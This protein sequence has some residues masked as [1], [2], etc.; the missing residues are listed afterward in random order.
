MTLKHIITWT[1]F[2]SLSLS[3]CSQ[4]RESNWIPDR[5]IGLTRGGLSL[6]VIASHTLNVP[7]DTLRVSLRDAVAPQETNLDIIDMAAS[8]KHILIMD[9]INDSGETIAWIKKNW[10]QHAGI[11][12]NWGE[13]VRVA[14]LINNIS[15]SEVV[16]FVGKNINKHL[17]P[18]WIV[19]PWEN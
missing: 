13:T 3:L 19:F 9:D 4:I 11:N 5:I 12:I 6:A 14:V 16:D 18:A 8:G 15:S 7:M 17:D 10:N 2:H 1:E